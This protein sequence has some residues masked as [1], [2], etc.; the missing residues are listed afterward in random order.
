ME[1]VLFLEKLGIQHF[2]LKPENIV[3]VKK[4]ANFASKSIV[5]PTLNELAPDLAE[6]HDMASVQKLF[7]K[8]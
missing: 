5:P 4:K 8:L 1:S 3:L 2:D 7:S 6:Y